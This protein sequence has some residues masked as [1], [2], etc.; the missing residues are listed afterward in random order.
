MVLQ[1]IDGVVGGADDLDVV[2]LHQTAGEELGL[3]QLLG[4]LVVNLARGLRA[5]QVGDA[6]RRL[7]LQVGPVVQGVAHGIR[8][9]LCPLLELLPIGSILACAEPLVDAVGTHGAPLVMVALQPDFRQVVEAVVRGHV[10]WNEVAMVVDDRHLGGVLVVEPFGGTRL[11]QE[12]VVVE[13]FHDRYFGL[14]FY[15]VF[16]M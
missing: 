10:P 8:N 7:E 1:R 2:V 3:L 5:E 12:V 13:L 14:D 6:E 15:A 4:A 11:Q 16:G 9:R